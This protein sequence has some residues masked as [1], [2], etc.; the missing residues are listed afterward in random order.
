MQ[1]CFAEV[2]YLNN[3]NEYTNALLIEYGFSELNSWE[4]PYSNRFGT[5]STVQIGFAAGVIS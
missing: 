4:F 1:R 3:V 2:F 5:N